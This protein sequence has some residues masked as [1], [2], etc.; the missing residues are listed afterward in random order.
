MI[1]AV[2]QCSDS[3]ICAAKAGNSPRAFCTPRMKNLKCA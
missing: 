2:S 1:L 3:E